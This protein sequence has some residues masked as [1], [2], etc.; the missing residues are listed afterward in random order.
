MN[1]FYWLPFIVIPL[2]CTSIKNQQKSMTKTNLEKWVRATINIEGRPAAKYDMAKVDSITNL[3]KENRITSK[4]LSD[5]LAFMNA[6]RPRFSGSAVYLL[7][8]S[9]HYLITA[10]HV[11]ED[12]SG[13]S[14][15]FFRDMYL[16]QN[17]S[18]YTNNQDKGE[19]WFS[20]TYG[21]VSVTDRQ[22]DFA[23]IWLEKCMHGKGLIETLK[24]RGYEPITMAD[25]D[26]SGV[27][28]EGQAIHSIGFP[29]DFYDKQKL[30]QF[31][32]NVQDFIWNS[33]F[34][35]FPV[36]SYG[37]VE[38]PNYRPHF[39]SGGIFIYHG[40][41]GGAV[42]SNNKLVGIVHGFELKDTKAADYRFVRYYNR[43]MLLIKMDLLIP[44][45][46]EITSINTIR[47]P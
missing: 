8:D 40:N 33:N 17:A 12:T 29:V 23:V 34:T 39:F 11:L 32:I 30:P 24:R 22:D 44:A 41:S 36:V 27:L 45:L 43:H 7:K 5:Q 18:N 3:F 31:P 4:E 37:S 38:S 10:R 21:S 15:K 28:T 16:I 1:L 47:R 26:V 9:N 20:T 6:N 2:S 19:D 13:E 46:S 25:I 42:V 35:S 14:E